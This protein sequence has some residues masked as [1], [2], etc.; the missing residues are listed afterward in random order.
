M[1]E[2]LLAVCL[3]GAPDVCETQRLPGGETDA[4]CRAASRELAAAADPKWVVQSHP[5]APVGTTPE[6]S[7][8][9]IAPGV[10]VHQGRHAEPAPANGGDIANLS[11][12]VGSEA[13]AVIDAGTTHAIADKLLASIARVTDL[14]VRWLV[15]THMHPDH[16]LGTAR[17]V[18]SGAEV[19]SHAK[20]AR[21]LAA[22][23]ETYRAAMERLLGPA[24]DGTDL[25]LPQEGIT[26]ATIID[27]GDRVLEIAPHATAHT[28]NDLTVLDRATATLFAGDLLFVD[29]TPALDGSLTGWIDVLDALRALPAERAVP[30]H[31]P[32]SVPWPDGAEPIAGYLE[33]IASQTRSALARGDPM[34]RAIEEVGQSERG[35]WLLFDDYTPRNA[36]AAFK[37]LEWE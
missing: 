15:L 11:F 10:F 29:R 8:S 37:E 2:V 7:I 27:L 23:A 32:V 24:F 35:A 14:P 20:L 30:G 36:T 17:I 28:D 16:V 21:A 13:V 31:G 5:C 34:T 6:F 33:T 26:E 1:F 3:A 25:Y 19:I 4:A 22:R 9:E 12:V 18:E